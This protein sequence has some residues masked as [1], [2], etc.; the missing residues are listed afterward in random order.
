M[1]S[2]GETS[3]TLK[4]LVGTMT[5]NA[6]TSSDQIVYV[7]KGYIK[8]L[9]NLVGFREFQGILRTSKTNVS[10][11]ASTSLGD[12]PSDW[13]KIDKLQRNDTGKEMSKVKRNSNIEGYF[14]AGWNSSTSRWQIGVTPAVSSALTLDLYYFRLPDKLDDSSN[15]TPLIP[16]A[17]HELIAL[18]GAREWFM[19]QQDYVEAQNREN[20][21]YNKFKEIMSDLFDYQ[22]SEHM[23]FSNAEADDIELSTHQFN[24][25]N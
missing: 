18:W 17:F 9:R 20:D 25:D 12:L 23:D 1:V 4:A 7:N 5:R 10:I 13:L 24:L 15:T 22:E 21:Y 11:S 6:C 3:T 16:V 19:D 8:I 14:F 2:F